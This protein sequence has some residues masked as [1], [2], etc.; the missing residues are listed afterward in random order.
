MCPRPRKILRQ[1][2][3][4]DDVEVDLMFGEEPFRRKQIAYRRRDRSTTRSLRE[5]TAPPMPSAFPSTSDNSFDLHSASV[6]QPWV[7]HQRRAR[8]PAVIRRRE[9]HQFRQVDATH[10]LLI[11]DISRHGYIGR[12]IIGGKTLGKRPRLAVDVSRGGRQPGKVGDCINPYLVPGRVDARESAQTA[13]RERNLLRSAS[14]QLP[15][16]RG[17]GALDTP[18]GLLR[19]NPPG[20]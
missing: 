11:Q 3:F 4:A 8:T 16:P 10:K 13:Y 17:S 7:L 12:R 2:V 15:L 14:V 19:T 9:V 6:R 20:P 18:D 5:G 1:R